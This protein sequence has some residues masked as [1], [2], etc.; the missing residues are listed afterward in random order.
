MHLG[1]R[2]KHFYQKAHNESSQ[3]NLVAVNTVLLNPTNQIFHEIGDLYRT[4]LFVCLLVLKVFKIGFVTFRD[5]EQRQH[6][7][8]ILHFNKLRLSWA[9][10]SQIWVE[11]VG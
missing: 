1:M 5:D 10:L 9:K 3:G 2:G 7:K 11:A 6:T 8:Q 4:V